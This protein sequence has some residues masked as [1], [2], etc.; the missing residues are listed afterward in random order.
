MS[1]WVLRISTDRE[2]GHPPIEE[3]GV[4]FRLGWTLVGVTGFS[5]LWWSESLATSGPSAFLFLVFEPPH[6]KLPAITWNHGSISKAFY[7][8]M[9]KKSCLFLSWTRGMNLTP[10]YLAQNKRDSCL[11]IQE[12][13]TLLTCNMQL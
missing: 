10:N 1:T 12:K 5:T 7:N 4:R 2:P 8:N 13:R 6:K 11:A 9:K 3:V